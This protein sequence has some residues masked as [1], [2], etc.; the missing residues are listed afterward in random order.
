M[1]TTEELAQELR[2]IPHLSDLTDE[3]AAWLAGQVHEQRLQPG[4]VL[5]HE[6]E[7]ADR[8]LIVFTGEI[9]SRRERGA[10]DGRLYIARAGEVTGLLPFSRMTHWTG[11]VRAVVPT[12]IAWLPA[13]LFPEMLR[14]IPALE[15][16]LVGALTDRVRESA[17]NDQQREKLMALG[18]LSAGLAH[19][20]N[21]PSAAVQ[22]AVS[23]LTDCLHRLRDL[24]VRLV[25]CGL[26]PAAI[27]AAVELRRRARER[28]AAEIARRDAADPLAVAD[29]ESAVGDWLEAH[30]IERPWLA[31]ATFTAAGIAP[32][33]LDA[34]AAQVRDDVLRCVLDWLEGGLAA[35]ALLAD[36][37]SATRRITELVGAV[38]SY[39]HMD[40]GQGTSEVDVARDIDSTL[41]I[42][43]H[44]VREKGVALTRDYAPDLPR[45]CGYAGELNQVWTNL[46]DN[47]LDAVPSG[48]HIAVRAARENDHL[49]IEIRDDGPGV[50]AEIQQ[51]IWEPFF[52]TKPV[53]QGTGLGLDIA[54]SIV[55]RRHGGS[56][57]LTSR[58]GDTRFAV[59]LP[60]RG[61]VPAG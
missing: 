39:S 23:E 56:I 15:A 25:E 17:R 35:E 55:T 49:L 6:G 21:N 20:L 48:G 11:T 53:G 42:L 9:H 18:K 19:E 38:K 34:L 16:R 4:E 27:R 32:T 51:R 2:R 44:K 52:T 24:T 46:L 3:Q 47:A 58:P 41:V 61:P 28:D 54:Q 33:D 12:H 1:S 10:A 26:D 43:G 30:G 22:R 40:E 7:P 37:A 8:M 31:A 60:L 13:D 29:R 59:R 14:R 57:A 36:V 50:P 45:V 5:A